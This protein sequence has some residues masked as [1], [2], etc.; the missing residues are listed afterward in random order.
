MPN[1]AVIQ[2]I[3][4]GTLSTPPISI[5]AHI[6]S[7]TD[8]DRA[9]IGDSEYTNRG[10]TV[11][12]TATSATVVHDATQR[13]IMRSTK[14]PT[15][16]LWPFYPTTDAAT[17]QKIGPQTAAH[18]AVLSSNRDF[19]AYVHASLGSPPESSVLKALSKGYLNNL[20]RLTAQILQ[21]QRCVDLTALKSNPTK[22]VR[23]I[24]KQ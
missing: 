5:P 18:S 3:A 4:T 24:L 21:V 2:S 1:G 13:I 6:F 10:C 15:A 7:N 19:V 22:K 11:I 16:R 14:E 20:P 9:L 23:L 8:L 12:L 17:I